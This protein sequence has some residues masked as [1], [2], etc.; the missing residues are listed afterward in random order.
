VVLALATVVCLC[1]AIVLGATSGEVRYNHDPAVDAAL[2][3][4]AMQAH[5]WVYGAWVSMTGLVAV[6]VVL[7][8]SRR[9]TP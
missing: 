8:W 9:E 3:T 4:M 5:R 7:Y 2:R 1:E 6:A